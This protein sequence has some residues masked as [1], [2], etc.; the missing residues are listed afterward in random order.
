M[1]LYGITTF[2]SAFL[3]FNVQMLLGKFVL[4]WHGGVPAVWTTCMLFFQSALLFG[5]GYAHWLAIRP[6]LTLQR[7]THIGLIAVSLVTLA[8]LA[9]AWHWPLLPDDAWR[10]RGEASPIGQILLLLGVAIGIQFV[11]LS[12]TAPLLQRWFS[13]THRGQSPYR[14][15]ALSNVGSLAGVL[16]Y[17]FVV[18]VFVPLKLQAALWSMGYAAFAAGMIAAAIV[19]ARKVSLVH[20]APGPAAARKDSEARPKPAR[21][22]LWFGL[23]ACASSLLLA[24]TNQISQEIAVVPFLWVLPFALYLLSFV[25]CFGGARGYPRNLYLTLLVPAIVLVTLAIP[26]GVGGPFVPQL[27]LY[28]AALFV[29]CMVCHGELVRLRPAPRYLTAFYLTLSAGGAAGGVFVGIIAPLYFPGYWE[30]SIALVGTAVLVGV[31]LWRDG[32][33]PLRRGSP[34][35]TYVPLLASALLVVLVYGEGLGA[36]AVT[37]FRWPLPWSY[38]A[39]LAVLAVLLLHVLVRHR[40]ALSAQI[41]AG[42]PSAA[43]VTKTG[44]AVQWGGWRVSGATRQFGA[45]A[46]AAA[47]VGFVHLSFA[48]DFVGSSVVAWRNFFG[49]LR[50]GASV[51]SHDEIALSLW[52]GRTLHGLQYVAHER[53]M[54][55]TAYYTPQSGIGRVLQGHARRRDGRPLRVGVVGLGV[56]TLAA[57][58]RPGDH[59]RFY[60]IN[61][62]VVRLAAGPEAL[63]TFVQRSEARVEIVL[64]DGRVSLERETPQRFDVLAIDAFNSGSIPVHLLTREAFAV[65]L[66]HLE[67]QA[68]VLALHVSNRYLDLTPVVAAL[69]RQLGLA[70]VAVH[71][72]DP[73]SEWPNEWLLLA[74]S[75]DALPQ[76]APRPAA[77]ARAPWTDDFSN[78]LHALRWTRSRETV[79]DNSMD[80]LANEALLLDFTR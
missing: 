63:F 72:S 22:L 49:V 67:P 7:N 5:Y 12:A 75:A 58:G 61:P 44:A 32:G 73:Q 37:S 16:S 60:E 41:H 50:V 57:Y 8:A 24:I 10:P 25:L 26:R 59:F 18:E 77:V 35:A 45:I 68:G 3:L 76:D 40:A 6:R 43:R 62:D 36:A 31:A 42:G 29:A 66:A 71:L 70:L 54:T 52:H 33:S 30:L 80:V 17:P 1:W 23:A 51:E 19:A 27:L 78:L 48:R 65:Y 4:P 34:A 47:L 56:G 55:P 39:V 11:T 69:A 53:G 14:L 74:R 38:V 2:L 21:L 13:L 9:M 46:G 28:A 20:D 15:Y 79:G 64:G